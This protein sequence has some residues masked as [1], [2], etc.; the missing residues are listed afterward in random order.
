MD[1]DRIR[2]QVDVLD[3]NGI[4]TSH[5]LGEISIREDKVGLLC[6]DENGD[7]FVSVMPECEASA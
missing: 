6:L 1:F 3:E 4:A 2:V 7:P 5:D